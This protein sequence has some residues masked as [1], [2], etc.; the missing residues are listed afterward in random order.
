VNGEEKK[1]VEGQL[2]SFDDSLIHE[3][4]NNTSE[5][6]IVM[7]IDIAK[8][9]GMYSKEEICSYKINKMDD[10]F[11]LSLASKEEWEKMYKNKEISLKKITD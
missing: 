2:V 6:R 9:N 8:P 7:M 4:W 3:A 11:L 5:D 10:P 1:W